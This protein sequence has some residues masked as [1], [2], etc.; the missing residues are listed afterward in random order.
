MFCPIIISKDAIALV[1]FSSIIFDLDN[2]LYD[3]KEFNIAAYHNIASYLG[4]LCN[5]SEKFLFDELF[6]MFQKKSS[7]Y[8]RLFDDFIKSLGL[9]KDVVPKLLQIFALTKV[10]LKL[11]SG[12]EDLLQNLKNKGIKLCLVTNGNVITQQNKVKQ[13]GIAKF[14]N[15][16][17]YA[18]DMG[19]ENEKPNPIAYEK[20][21]EMLLVKSKE[22]FCV[23]DNPYTDFLSAKKLGIRTIRLLKGEFKNVR[24]SPDYEADVT[25]ENFSELTSFFNKNI[26]LDSKL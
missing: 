3:E 17:I 25:V 5:E 19:K 10:D 12:A 16:I 22:T 6:K 24:L 2:T 11:Y 14:F 1:F 23:G 7:M 18:R 9:K 21:L 20:A 13:L 8:P 15:V 4:R 26:R